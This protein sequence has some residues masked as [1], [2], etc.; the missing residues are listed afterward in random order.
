M[1]I[2]ELTEKPEESRVIIKFSGSVRSEADKNKIVNAIQKYLDEGKVNFIFDFS[3]LEY[4]NSSG[5]GTFSYFYD[6]I[7]RQ[8]KGSLVICSPQDRVLKL[9]QITNLH[10]ILDIKEN[11]ENI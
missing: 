4:I 1:K 7:V 3:N 10:I 5:I 2:L 11:C 8:N 6:K 9:F